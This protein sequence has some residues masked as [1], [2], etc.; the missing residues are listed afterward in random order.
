MK[1]MAV[2]NPVTCTRCG[3]TRNEKYMTV[4]K[5]AAGKP[6]VRCR[7]K[8]VCHSIAKRTNSQYRASVTA[9]SKKNR[10]A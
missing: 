2:D 3:R 6:R 10:K 9:Y 1:T 8:S 5:N 7:K 4:R